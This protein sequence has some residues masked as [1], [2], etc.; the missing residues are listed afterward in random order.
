MAERETLEVVAEEMGVVVASEMK[1]C[2]DGTQALDVVD[3]IVEDRDLCWSSG[4][5]RC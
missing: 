2:R 3:G 1:P 5:A 4:W